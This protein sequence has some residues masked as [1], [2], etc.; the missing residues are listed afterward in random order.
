VSTGHLRHGP[1]FFPFL[2]GFRSTAT[3]FVIPDLLD[4]N[5]PPS[6]VLFTPR[7]RPG[8][9]SDPEAMTGPIK[10]PAS[11]GRLDVPHRSYSSGSVTQHR[12]G[13]LTAHTHTQLRRGSFPFFAPWKIGHRLFPKEVDPVMSI[14]VINTWIVSR[15]LVLAGCR[16]NTF[17]EIQNHAELP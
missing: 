14:L 3:S 7:D 11:W 13:A 12:R 15:R 8:P 5:L 4:S 2:P 16:K 9:E 6:V 1:Q 10:S 17:S